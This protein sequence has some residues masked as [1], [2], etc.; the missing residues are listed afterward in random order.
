MEPILLALV[1]LIVSLLDPINAAV[2]IA[3]GLLWWRE[4][5]VSVGIAVLAMAAW[6]WIEHANSVSF[7]RPFSPAFL[8]QSAYAMSVWGAGVAYVMWRRDVRASG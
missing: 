7:Q 3:I 8:L 2:G 6:A 5:V 1:W 4:R